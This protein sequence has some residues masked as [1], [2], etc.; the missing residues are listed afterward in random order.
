MLGQLPVVVAKQSYSE[1]VVIV[2]LVLGSF[3]VHRDLPSYY[4]V[5]H[6]Y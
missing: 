6:C 3:V 2:M 1:L 5:A 4:S